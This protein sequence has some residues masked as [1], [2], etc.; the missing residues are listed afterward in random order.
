MKLS[1]ISFMLAFLGNTIFYL[2]VS[3]LYF[4][5]RASVLAGLNAHDMQEDFQS[6]EWPLVFSFPSCPP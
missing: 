1:L 6:P 4:H 2:N 3:V 5:Q